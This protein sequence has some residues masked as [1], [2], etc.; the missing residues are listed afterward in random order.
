MVAIKNGTIKFVYVPSLFVELVEVVAVSSLVSSTERRSATSGKCR[1][2]G[3]QHVVGADLMAE[4]HARLVSLVTWAKKRDLVLLSAISTLAKSA[5]EAEPGGSSKVSNQRSTL[6]HLLAMCMPIPRVKHATNGVGLL[7]RLASE[8]KTTLATIVILTLTQSVRLA[9]AVTR[10]GI[11]K[12]VGVLKA[13]AVRS[14]VETEDCLLVETTTSVIKALHQSQLAKTQPA[15]VVGV[16]MNP[17]AREH[18][19]KAFVTTQGLA[20][21]VELMAK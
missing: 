21:P 19:I 7:E 15:S 12:C 1:R 2:M 17:A 20:S 18:A 14:D 3:G 9:M 4:S 6:A 13:R 8:G 11:T 16:R 5:T 10:D